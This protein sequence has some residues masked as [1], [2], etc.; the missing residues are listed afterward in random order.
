MRRIGLILGVLALALGAVGWW[1]TSKQPT[2]RPAPPITTPGTDNLSGAA[3]NFFKRANRSQWVEGTPQ[4]PQS[5][6]QP[7]GRTLV[8]ATVEER[9]TFNENLQAQP[10]GALLDLWLIEARDKQDALRLDFIADALS[11]QL[12][13]Q[14]GQAADVV[15]SIVQYIKDKNQDDFLR[16]RLVETLGDAATSGTLAVLL[17]LARSAEAY[18]DLRPIVLHQIARV[19]DILWD[20][21]FH[22]EL[23]PLLERARTEAAADE[24]LVT[25]LSIA[26]AKVGAPTSIEVLVKDVLRGGLTIPE[27]EQRNDMMAWAAYNALER[28]RNERSVPVLERALMEGQPGGMDM[29]ASGWALAH[30]GQPEATKVLLDWA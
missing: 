3:S 20:E 29:V 4:W 26:L 22:E 11:E 7:E 8:D 1:I 30:M 9:M 28:V 5:P 6:F 12:R 16:W 23:S 14:D 2:S 27:F 25:A 19:G 24:P 21:R 13:K 15:S 18:P 10:A 17:D